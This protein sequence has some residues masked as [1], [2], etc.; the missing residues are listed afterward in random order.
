MLMHE[1]GRLV[2]SRS[3]ILDRPR[4]TIGKSYSGRATSGPRGPYLVKLGFKKCSVNF[5]IAVSKFFL[6]NG[7]DVDIACSRK[8]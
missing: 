2:R 4:T 1:G 7:V 3:D 5:E 8:S 6:L